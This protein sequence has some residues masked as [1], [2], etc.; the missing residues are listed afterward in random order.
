MQ[1]KRVGGMLIKAAGIWLVI[2]AVAIANGVFREK[3]LVPLIGADFS[4][5]LSGVLLIILIFLVALLSVS[6]IGPSEQKEYILVG[7]VWAIFTLSFE[8]LFGYFVVGKSWQEM[9]GVFNIM[10]GD[11]FIVILF[12]TAVSPWLAA[13][14]R[15]II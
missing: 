7:V 6:I 1:E 4:L 13:K 9:L 15:G 11:L 14:T 8:F 2:V 3:V 12:A 10:K 5:P